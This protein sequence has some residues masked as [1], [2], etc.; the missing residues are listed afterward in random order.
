MPKPSTRYYNNILLS[1]VSVLSYNFNLLDK[2]IFLLTLFATV[3]CFRG[4]I[5]VE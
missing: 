3:M 2:Y 5:G 1:S 4:R